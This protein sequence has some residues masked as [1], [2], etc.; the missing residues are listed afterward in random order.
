MSPKRN[1][2]QKKV[3]KAT[4]IHS[5]PDIKVILKDYKKDEPVCSF[6]QLP[7]NFV[8]ELG[9]LYGPY[10]PT[11][12][13]IIEY[14]NDL[15]E[16]QSTNHKSFS[17]L[18]LYE[19]S[20]AKIIIDITTRKCYIPVSTKSSDEK[21]IQSNLNTVKLLQEDIKIKSHRLRLFQTV[22][23]ILSHK[24]WR[25]GKPQIAG[26]TGKIKILGEIKSASLIDVIDKIIFYDV[27][28][29]I[30]NN[31]ALPTTMSNH[32]EKSELCEPNNH[33]SSSH[34]KNINLEKLWTHASCALWAPGVYCVKTQ[35]FGM[36][37]S[38]CHSKHALCKYCN[39]HGA[40]ISQYKD[41]SSAF[42]YLCAVINGIDFK[43]HSLLN[44]GAD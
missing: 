21:R 35:L 1:S 19:C 15:N 11:V 13:E 2:K 8:H 20:S 25:S 3:T 6:C 37:S 29:S 43:S 30:S 10:Y 27:K 33:D 26:F 34:V 31:N 24:T 42:H 18:V 23:S 16:N 12:D 40:T 9:D 38:V 7:A 39:R 36:Y 44:E 32:S 22:D 4:D 28:Q 5:Y 14:H 17:D 41:K